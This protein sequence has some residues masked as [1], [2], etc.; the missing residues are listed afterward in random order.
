M[1]KLSVKGLGD[2]PETL[3]IPLAARILAPSLNPD[4]GF[5]DPA[6]PQIAERLAFDPARYAGDRGSMRGSIVRAQWFDG[7][8]RKFIAVHPDGLAISLGSGLDARPQ[9]VGVP[10][11][12]DWVDLDFPEVVALRRALLPDSNSIAADATDVAGWAAALPWR[13][14]RPALVIAEGVLMYF[15]PGAAEATIAAIARTARARRSSLELTFDFASPLMVAQSRRHPSVSKTN[16]RFAWALPRPERLDAIAP[17]LE[18]VETYDIMRRSGA[19][20]RIISA[21]YGLLS[22]RRFYGA[23]RY[24]LTQ[25]A[26]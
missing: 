20:A 8:A 6:A 18:L 1:T 25:D 14:G 10:A 9:R 4:L 12:F 13:E 21:T 22:R 26:A 3:L 16:A 2:V 5:D 11:G 24:R 23:A 19:M 15:E 17:G 7:V